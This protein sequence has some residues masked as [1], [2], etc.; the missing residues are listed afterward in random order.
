MIRAQ[1]DTLVENISSFVSFFEA[2]ILL[3]PFV[4]NILNLC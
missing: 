3:K 1:N 2:I 4:K